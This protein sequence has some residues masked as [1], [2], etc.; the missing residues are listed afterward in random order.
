[1]KWSGSI[2]C[3][4]MSMG[5]SSMVSFGDRCG[6]FQFGG[7]RKGEK[8]LEKKWGHGRKVIYKCRDDIPP[9]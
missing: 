6:R 3:Q 8:C 7:G 9:Y 2:R 5:F 1:M 4:K